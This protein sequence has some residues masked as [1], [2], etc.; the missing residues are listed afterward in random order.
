MNVILA[1]RSSWLFALL[2]GFNIIVYR[3]F[4]YQSK[5]QVISKSNLQHQAQHDQLTGLPNLRFLLNNFP[6]WINNNKGPFTVIFIDLDDFKNSNDL[7]GRTVGNKILCEVADRI[8]HYFNDCLCIR[9]SADEFLVIAPH[10]Y[11]DSS[12]S[13]CHRFLQKLKQPIFIDELEFIIRASL[14]VAQ[15]P[16]DGLDIESLISK[17]DIAMYEA[18]RMKSGVS[19]FS[20]ELDKQN[21][22]IALIG[23]ELN[24]AIDRNEFSMVYQP[25][26]NNES[27]KF[28]GVEALLRWNNINLGMVPPDYKPT[29]C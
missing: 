16:L 7:H 13:V 15:S 26:Y 22:R 12:Q 10:V 18:K 29:I 23:K 4:K 11:D 25:Q 21:A 19:I 17:A 9:Q 27:K 6:Q 1:I 2:L 3:L 24:S 8:K 14:G 5:L 20:K 28:I